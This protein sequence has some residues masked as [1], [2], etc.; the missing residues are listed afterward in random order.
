M[1]N[2]IK[3]LIK[4]QLCPSLLIELDENE[5]N[6]LVEDIKLAWEFIN[7]FDFDQFDSYE[8]Y[9]FA[10]LNTSKTLRKDEI[11]QP[12]S[13]KKVLMNIEDEKEGLIKV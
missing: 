12:I 7:Q 9:M 6:L 4:N 13:Q 1:D 11:N 3:D 2:H 10:N 5:I 8:P